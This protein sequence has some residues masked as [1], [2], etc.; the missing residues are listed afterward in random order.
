MERTALDAWL[1]DALFFLPC[2]TVD[3]GCTLLESMSPAALVIELRNLFKRNCLC[4][5]DSPCVLDVRFE[6]KGWVILCM[7]RQDK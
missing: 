3:L 2:S 7:I 5:E 4:L 1:N 6:M